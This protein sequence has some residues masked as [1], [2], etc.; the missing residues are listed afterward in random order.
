M[1]TRLSIV[2]PATIPEELYFRAYE[3]LRVGDSPSDPSTIRGLVQA[4][5]SDFEAYTKRILFT[6][7]LRAQYHKWYTRMPLT[8]WPVSAIGSV[9]YADEDGV[10]QT[11]LATQW[12]TDLNVQPAEIRFVDDFDYPSWQSGNPTPIEVQFT[13]GYGSNLSDV[14]EGILCGLL[15]YAGHLYDNR[16]AAGAEDLSKIKTAFW[17][18]H[19]LTWL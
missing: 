12:H 19:K 2:T 13:A 5:V 4:A 6:K 15:L 16:T 8:A 3:H 17:E 11:V 9:T 1:K 18:T 7:V 10:T 14:P